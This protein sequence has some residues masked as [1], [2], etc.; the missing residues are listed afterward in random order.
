MLE[1]LG[2]IPSVAKKQQTT[3]AARSGGSCG[4]LAMRI[5]TNS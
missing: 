2:A 3:D 5:A 4:R 1:G